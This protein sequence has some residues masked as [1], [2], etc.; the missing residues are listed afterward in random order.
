MYES[1]QSGPA[2]R[3]ELREALRLLEAARVR[4]AEQLQ[5]AERVGAP[6]LELLRGTAT[7]LQHEAERLRVLLAF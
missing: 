4:H 6:A 1:G 3:Q 7:L 2:W 5:A